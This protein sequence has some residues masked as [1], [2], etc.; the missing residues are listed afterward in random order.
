V[1]VVEAK[2]V[3]AKVV[4]VVESS[5]LHPASSLNSRKPFKSERLFLCAKA[6][7]ASTR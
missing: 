2:V 6:K 3:V 5:S 4:V 7:I 1:A